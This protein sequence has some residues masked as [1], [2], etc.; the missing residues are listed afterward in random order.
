MK[1]NR[2]WLL[3]EIARGKRF[4][5]TGFWGNQSDTKEERSFSNFYPSKFTV[6]TI[7]GLHTFTCSEQYF[8]YL[9]AV[10]FGDLAIVRKILDNTLAPNHYKNLGRK[11]S[12]F[13]DNKWSRVRY[14]RML[15]CLRAKFMQNDD[16]G[17]NLLSTGDTILVEASP[18]DTVWGVKLSKQTKEGK[19]L[20]Q[21]SDP[22]QWRG[23]NLLGFALMEVRDELKE[24]GNHI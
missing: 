21:W 13:D 5:Y 15:D 22:T 6:D 17:K 16:L 9:K 11:V 18:F 20:T 1:Y 10:E 7:Q 24:R 12:G 2:Q 23:D 8:M 19:V 3:R 14:Q 4:T